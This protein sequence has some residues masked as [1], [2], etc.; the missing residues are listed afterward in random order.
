[1]LVP[2]A[3]VRLLFDRFVENELS[4]QEVRV[5][6]NPARACLC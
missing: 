1:M 6:H 5:P 2:A 3:L 4:L